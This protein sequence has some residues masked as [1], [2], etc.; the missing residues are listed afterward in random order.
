M[1]FGTMYFVMVG[2]MICAFGLGY[3]FGA[4]SE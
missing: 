4:R 1:D 2:C 3:M